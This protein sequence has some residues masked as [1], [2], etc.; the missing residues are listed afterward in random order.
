MLFMVEWGGMG[1]ANKKFYR[2]KFAKRMLC[3]AQEDTFCA[4]VWKDF[5]S[6]SACSNRLRI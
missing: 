6:S 3:W 1:S 2:Y 4:F 5:S